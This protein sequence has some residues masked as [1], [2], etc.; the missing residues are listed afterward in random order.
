VL[1]LGVIVALACPSQAKPATK[2]SNPVIFDV[3]GE[4]EGGYA[5]SGTITIDTKSGAILS[6]FI[7]VEG[8]GIGFNDTL[9]HEYLFDEFRSTNS[10]WVEDSQAG[11]RAEL[12]I[13]VKNLRGYTGGPLSIQSLFEIP[14]GTFEGMEFFAEYF[15][16]SG[17]LTPQ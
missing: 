16:I 3:T 14:W 4:F 9:V 2:T 15:L 8:G 6:A 13:P 17:S 10:V 1:L 11:D 5:L 7:I 12:V